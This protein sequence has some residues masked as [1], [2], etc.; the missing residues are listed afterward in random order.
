MPSAPVVNKVFTVIDKPVA[1]DLSAQQAKVAQRAG[2]KTIAELTAFC[3]QLQEEK[4][5]INSDS[6]SATAQAGEEDS[7]PV[8]HHP[9]LIR[10]K[11]DITIPP[12]IFPVNKPIVPTVDSS[13]PLQEQFPVSCG[14]KH[15]EKETVTDGAEVVANVDGSAIQTQPIPE[16]FPQPPA[17]KLDISELVAKRMDA[18]R[19][20][21]GNPNDIEALLTLQEI[22]MKMQNWC[23]SNVKPGQYTGELVKNLLPKENLQG[24]FQ[25]WVK[26]DM[27]QNLTPVSG[28]IGMKLLQKMGW[29]PGQVIGKRGEGYAEPIAVTV[30]IDRKG[31]SAGKEKAA[32]KGAPAVLDLQGKHPVSALAEYCSKRK[33][34]L[35]DYT[36][37]FDH[38]PAHHK[39][40]LFKV[41]VNSVEY[42]P[43]VVCGNKK[44]AKAQAAI[45]ALK[46]LGLIPEDADISAV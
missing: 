39:Q 32:K 36:L 44:Q 25:A 2:G 10:D 3:K 38:G 12:V 35:P 6:T 41:L 17:E 31:L 22:Q 34:Q 1:S 21:Q 24:G 4:E 40:F 13:K 15:R 28:G 43:A 8:A 5:S 20:L 27:F 14:S 29:K 26:K 30:K 16:V 23:Q 11:P 45:Y 9:F 33:W 7:Q 42:Q 18:Q 46:G 19:R 37:I